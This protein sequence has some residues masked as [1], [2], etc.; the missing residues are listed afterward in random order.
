MTAIASYNVDYD[1]DIGGR[2]AK[3]LN[4]VVGQDHRAV[5]SI[6]RIDS[7]STGGLLNRLERCSKSVMF[8]Q[9]ASFR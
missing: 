8:S 2:Q 7:R 1:A 9:A 4:N 3:Y 5:K 6:T